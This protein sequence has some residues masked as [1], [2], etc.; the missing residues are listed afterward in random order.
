MA[1]KVLKQGFSSLF[2][3]NSFDEEESVTTLRISDIEP[4]RSQ[5]RKNFDRE[6]LQSLADSIKNNGLI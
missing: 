5:P 2:D 3:D 4:D 1:K 6:A